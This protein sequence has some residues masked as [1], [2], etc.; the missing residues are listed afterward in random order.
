MYH[1]LKNPEQIAYQVSQLLTQA[2]STHPD[3]H[4]GLATGSTMKP[5]YT[6]L[7]K[8]IHHQSLDCSRLTT[9]NLDEYIGLAP[10]HP[11]S[12]HYFMKEQLFVPLN[13]QTE[14][15]HIPCGVATDTDQEAAAYSQEIEQA[16]GIDIQL[17][18]IGTNGHI[19]FNEP[20]TPFDSLTHVVQLSDNTRID[21]SRFFESFDEM[22]T[23]AITMGL[24]D[25]MRAKHIILVVTGAHKAQV[26]LDLY[27]SEV[28]PQMPASI[29]KNHSNV[30]VF[31]DEAAAKL[32]IEKYGHELLAANS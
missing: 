24:E 23:H 28:T 1:I 31:L 16:G 21:N 11:Q 13:I 4:L 10:E 3:L 12:Y 15:V 5:V 19:G 2:L 14:Q 6:E 30:Q 25:I 29:L 27:E 7:I 20:G 26:A 18:G 32:I 22:P 17:L 9:F 8:Q